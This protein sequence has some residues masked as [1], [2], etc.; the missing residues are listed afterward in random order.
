[1]NIRYLTYESVTEGHPDKVADQISDAVLDYLIERD[2][3]SRVGC[4]TMLTNGLCIVAG[5]IKT[6]AYA[7]IQE[8]A[9]D[10]IRE[11]G[12]TDANFG[13]DYRS[14]GV[15]S[16]VSEQ[17]YDISKAIEK[18]NEHIGA[19]D[20]AVV[21]GYACNETDECMPLGVILA[22]RLAQ[23][24]AH[25]RKN[26]KLAFLRPDGKAQVTVKYVDGKPRSI[27]S[28][29]ISTQHAEETPL[30]I[31]KEDIIEEVIQEVIPKELLTSE[32]IY[33]INPTNRFVIG[34]PLADTGLTGRK[35]I[36]DSYGCNCPHGGGAFSG[37]DP[38]KID[39][40]S[41]YM[42]RYITKNF[43]KAGVCDEMTMALSYV[44]ADTQPICIDIELK[45]N[46]R[47]SKEAVLDCIGKLFDL[48]PK[49][50]I[51]TLDLL[52]P[53]YKKTSN[54]GH[55]GREEAGLNW[56][57]CDKVDAIKEYLE[58]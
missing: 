18:E 27:H 8:I 11:I 43:V 2:P 47:A 49:G 12:Y 57:K 44:I 52:Q 10:V 53:I 20:Q 13:F 3:K 29:I 50:I 48:S 16:S 36:I 54:Y 28:V 56:E 31:I 7:P 41:A 15:L 4:E 26:G 23:K 14:A 19:G 33:K 24:L 5:E 30:S 40:S 22:N 51:Q 6:E 42:A 32:T 25:V 45:G 55:F 58:I 17:S 21:Y 37:K 9:R 35:I 39:R 34:G 46:L 38:S 1:M